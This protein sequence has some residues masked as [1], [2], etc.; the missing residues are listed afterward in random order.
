LF[1]LTFYSTAQTGK[2]FWYVAPDASSGHGDSPLYIRITNVA[3]SG[4]TANVTIKMPANGGFTT[5]NV[6][7]A[8]GKQVSVE[9]NKGD[10]ENSP[11]NTVNN[12]GLLIESDQDV[13]V[14]YEINHSNNPDKFTLKGENA[15]GTDFYIPS[16]NE[17][18][19][20]DLTPKG[21][22]K[23]DIVATEN[24]TVV[25]IKPTA[26]CVG[27][28]AGIEFSV[29]LNRGQTYCLEA[30]DESIPGTLSGT[31]ISSDKNIAVTISDDSIQQTGHGNYDIIGDQLIPTSVLGTEYIAIRTNTGT[32]GN[33]QKVYILAIEDNTEV[34]Y[35]SSTI[36]LQ[37]GQ[38]FGTDITGNSL[39]I[40]TSNPV[41]VYQVTGYGYEMGSAI[42][43]S[44]SCTGSTKVSIKRNLTGAFWVQIMVKTID[45]NNF[46]LRDINGNNVNTD[47]FGNNNNKLVWNDVSGTT[48]AKEW[49]TAI[50]NLGASN[51]TYF[52]IDNPYTLENSSGK[53]HL[54]VL[55]ENGASLSYGYFSAY[56][57]LRV[58]G[59]TQ[60]CKGTSI[61][62]TTSADPSK[63]DLKWYLSPNLVDVLSTSTT[64][65]IENSISGKYII[66]AKEKDVFGCE[67]SA[68]LNVDFLGADFD[69]P[70]DTTICSNANITLNGPTGTPPYKYLWEYNTTTATTQDITFNV[71]AGTTTNVS[72][73]VTDD[74]NCAV[75]DEM[76]V[77]TYTVPPLNLQAN[78]TSIC[79]GQKI[80]SS[81]IMDRYQWYLNGVIIPNAITNEYVPTTS[82]K[83]TLSGW[84]ADDCVITEDLTITVNP[85]P[86]VSLASLTECHGSSETFIGPVGMASYLWHDGSTGSQLSITQPTATITLDVTD[87]NGC[88]SSGTGS[89]AWWDNKDATFT[90]MAC[91]TYDIVLETSSTFTNYAWTFQQTL[92]PAPVPV[93]PSPTAHQYSIT[94]ADAAFHEGTYIVT[95][96]DEHACPVTQT[97]QLGVYPIPK[98]DFDDATSFKCAGQHIVLKSPYE[99]DTYSWTRSSDGYANVISNE[100]F[101]AI[102]DDGNETYRLTVTQGSCS[103]S[104]EITVSTLPSPNIA[105]STGNAITGCENATIEVDATP[106]GGNGPAYSFQWMNDQNQSIASGT[107]LST[108][109]SGTFTVVVY[110]S[111]SCTD[112]ATVVIDRHPLTTFTLADLPPFC[113][114]TTITLQ[115]P[116]TLLP[117]NGYQWRKA[118]NTATGPVDADWVISDAGSYVLDI[119]DTNGCGASA[120]T[121]LIHN[122]SPTFDLGADMQ[123]KCDGDLI[124]VKAKSS[125]GNYYWNGD[126]TPGQPSVYTIVGN[127]QVQTISLRITSSINNC[128]SEKSINVITHTL[129]LVDLGSDINVCAG[130]R[131][132]LTAPDGMNTIMWTTPEGTTPAKTIIAKSGI[133]TLAVTDANG[134]KNADTINIVWRPLPVIDL[135]PD[136]LICPVDQVILDAGAGSSYYWEPSNEVTQ[137]IVAMTDTVTLVRV[138]GINGCWGWDTKVVYEKESPEYVLSPDT[139][140]CSNDSLLLDADPDGLY[141]TFLWSDGVITPQNMIKAPGDYWVEVQDGCFVLRDTTTITFL[142][143][144]VIAQLDTMIYQQIGILSTGGTSPYQYAI[145]DDEYQKDN[146]FRDLPNGTY[147]LWVQDSNLCTDS[148]TVSI[149]NTL[150]LN[151]PNFITPNGDGQNDTWAIGGLEK[152]PES[153]IRIYDRYGKLLRLY[154]PTEPA[155]DGR[156]LNKP[157]ASDDY[158]YVVELNPTNKLMK[159]NITLKR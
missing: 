42:L 151:I 38:S 10:V 64:Y 73:T 100:R 159:G 36:V 143:T 149:F 125:F 98:L 138:Q 1:L 82:G 11:S 123:N 144:P 118:D 9:V 4:Q 103:R 72:L 133:H 117:V 112:T 91:P 58:S 19:N 97:F 80:T 62:L 54:S 126:L 154:K 67:S 93:I 33:I 59:P 136:E 43:P 107:R 81:T 31:H 150:D 40:N 15:L 106:S 79:I 95:A 70:K 153:N 109:E 142:P 30:I 104:D 29:T 47:Y 83:Y 94:G 61:T 53:F 75:K 145:N 57:S 18:Y 28:P 2:T 116:A 120:S 155:W 156:Y 124:E 148:T 139:S 17:Y 7:V 52:S 105:L 16:Q 3:T 39:Y 48:P 35:G 114:N 56:N 141:H 74:N 122:P 78:P 158:W 27:H 65:K 71:T 110:D 77:N 130:I 22:E 119:T 25:K 5:Q 99:Y 37:K 41:Y 108:T 128:E 8:A 12:K 127:D 14:F 51:A 85:L 20:H 102:I 92:A 50:I 132:T 129:P 90:K 115:I 32:S 84:T 69:L 13:A 101:V 68:A 76:T 49:V 146:V 45:R 24:G 60:E 113:D 152:F 111:Q 23:I 86:V 131:S 147:V 89:Y 135:G 55:D 87:G 44:I 88:K 96:N 134:C 66:V 157:L 26:D 140:I 34:K 63:Y 46:I 6:T 21:K 137:T 121:E